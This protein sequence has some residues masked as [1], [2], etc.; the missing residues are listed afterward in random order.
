MYGA[1]IGDII[2]STY[3]LNSVKT[4]DFELLPEGSRF[5][6]DTVLTIAVV[7][8]I[9]NN[10]GFAESYHKW[11]NKYINVGF[12]SRF[13]QWLESDSL[14][15]SKSQGNGSAMRVSPCAWVSDNLEEVLEL[16]EKSAI[17]THNIPEGVKGAKAVALAIFLA[18]QG[19]SKE[20]IKG[21]IEE[22]IG[23]N[24]NNKI[25]D[26]RLDYQFSHSCP[27]SVPE[28]II[29]F[30][31]S[32]SYEDAVRKAVSLGGDADTQADIAGAVAEAFYGGVPQQLKEIVPN[33]LSEEM[34]VI[35]EE[36]NKKYMLT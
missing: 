34:M 21:Y 15:E 18:R 25:E 30:L 11:G 26:F 16:A 12:S 27:E 5:T 4:E 32:N 7:D 23:Y 9:L 28:A 35:I 14:E 31:E 1:I 36:F 29:C 24:L 3:E 2:G 17:C 22:T 10:I 20:E 13:R 6:D 19:N 8:S 33:Y